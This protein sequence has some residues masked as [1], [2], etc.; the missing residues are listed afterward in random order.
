MV[1]APPLAAY[2]QTEYLTGFYQNR[3]LPDI[4]APDLPGY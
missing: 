1:L 4:L 2:D 3:C